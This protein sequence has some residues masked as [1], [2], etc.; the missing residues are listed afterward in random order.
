MPFERTILNKDIPTEPL[1][2]GSLWWFEH[3]ASQMAISERRQ[4]EADRDRERATDEGLEIYGKIIS[5][6]LLADMLARRESSG[7][8]YDLA[9]PSPDELLLIYQARMVRDKAAATL[10]DA[11]LMGGD[12]SKIKSLLGDPEIAKLFEDVSGTR[13]G[14][15]TP[16]WNMKDECG[17]TWASL[18]ARSMTMMGKPSD[19]ARAAKHKLHTG[20]LLAN[21]LLDAAITKA[22]KNLA[23]VTSLSRADLEIDLLRMIRDS[24]EFRQSYAS[25]VRMLRDMNGDPWLICGECGTENEPPWDVCATCGSERE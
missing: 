19:A 20:S 22:A 25:V 13:Q 16:G 9:V 21:H 24:A 15:D 12:R 4:A 23:D 1:Y 18:L 2:E 5:G 3:M 8:I 7:I 14:Q 6:E 11:A 17:S 10:I